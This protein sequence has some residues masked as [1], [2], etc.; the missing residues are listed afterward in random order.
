ML[1]EDASDYLGICE[2]LSCS[3]PIHGKFSSLELPH[4]LERSPFG[5]KNAQAGLPPLPMD[6]P[7]GLDAL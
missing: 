7:G 6:R 1:K 4:L 3:T 2:S 5:G